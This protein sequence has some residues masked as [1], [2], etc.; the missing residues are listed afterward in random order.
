[1]A[2]RDE[3]HDLAVPLGDDDVLLAKDDVRD[4]GSVFLGRVQRG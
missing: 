1:V 3:A 2:H 4:E